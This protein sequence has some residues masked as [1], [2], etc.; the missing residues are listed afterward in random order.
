MDKEEE[1]IRLISQ[2]LIEYNAFYVKSTKDS[3]AYMSP[4]QCPRCGNYMPGG[5]GLA[6]LSRISDDI[7]DIYVCKECGQEEAIDDLTHDQANL[8]NIKNWEIAKNIQL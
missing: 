6:A 3:K 8:E 5:L 1:R 4:F 2:R 7:I